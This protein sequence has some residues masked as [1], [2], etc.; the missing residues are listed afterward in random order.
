MVVAGATLDATVI[1]AGGG[2]LQLIGI[3]MKS[4]GDINSLP[5]AMR[6]GLEPAIAYAMLLPDDFDPGLSPTLGTKKK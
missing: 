3:R 6:T 2:G 5:E 4:D 1:R